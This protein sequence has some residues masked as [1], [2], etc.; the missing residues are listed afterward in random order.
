LELK[1]YIRMHRARL[2]LTQQELAE[3]V[4]VSRQTIHAIERN[5]AEPSIGLALKLAR[6]FDLPL[7]ELFELV[8]G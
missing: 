6:L 7:D 2:D 3:R 5:K 4:G 1:N 8:E